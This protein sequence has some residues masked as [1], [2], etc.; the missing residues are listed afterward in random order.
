M[1]W[2]W[3][4]KQRKAPVA[5][6]TSNGVEEG[7]PLQG[8]LHS[9][10]KSICTLPLFNKCRDQAVA[11]CTADDQGE[12]DI[13]NITSSLAKYSIAPTL[14]DS[15]ANYN[16]FLERLTRLGVTVATSS[17]DN[18][19]VSVANLVQLCTPACHRHKAGISH[20]HCHSI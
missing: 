19:W 2:K 4:L 8:A 9:M 17:H 7:P 6:P 1:L 16:V 5:D 15:R 10:G 14:Q 13:D 3:Q 20:P 11:S 18:E 12:A